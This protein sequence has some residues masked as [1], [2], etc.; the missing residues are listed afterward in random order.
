[1]TNDT[2]LPDSW[3]ARTRRRPLCPALH[4]VLICFSPT[5]SGPVLTEVKARGDQHPFYGTVQVL[6]LES[7]VASPSQRRRPARHHQLR[8]D[9]PVDLCLVLAANPRYIF[10]P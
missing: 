3:P 10:E 8:P 5:V 7:Q 2:A 9:R 4:V 6:L 1:M